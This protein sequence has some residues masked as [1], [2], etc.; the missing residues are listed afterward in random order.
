MIKYLEAYC[1]LNEF[2]YINEYIEVG[3]IIEKQ[4]HE[5]LLTRHVNGYMFYYFDQLIKGEMQLEDFMQMGD[6]TSDVNIYA[7]QEDN[8]PGL[9]SLQEVTDLLQEWALSNAI[10]IVDTIALTHHNKL[11]NANVLWV[12]LQ[13]NSAELIAV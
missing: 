3:K 13:N 12:Q 4:E 6:I 11:D 5:K 1:D 10:I 7:Y 9:D 8:K 2:D